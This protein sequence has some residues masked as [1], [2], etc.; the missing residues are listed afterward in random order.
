MGNRFAL[1]LVALA[2]CPSAKPAVDVAKEV[3]ACQVKLTELVLLSSNCAEA[4]LRADGA[5]HSDP[6][7]KAA[8]PDGKL[9]V[10]KL[11]K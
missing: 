7:C 1:L 11:V 5:L 6:H 2:G 10:C 9:D 4:Q 8:F 3:D